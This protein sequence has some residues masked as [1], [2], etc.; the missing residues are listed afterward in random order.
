MGKIISVLINVLI[1]VLL[2]SICLG[3]ALATQDYFYDMKVK[4]CNSILDLEYK[5]G[6]EGVKECLEFQN[7]PTYN[8]YV[9]HYL[10]WGFLW[11]WFLVLQ[12]IIFMIMNDMQSS[13]RRI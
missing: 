9:P 7:Y 13:W 12:I 3:S 6:T 4:N 11:I 10:M 5:V 8:F 1:S 2:L